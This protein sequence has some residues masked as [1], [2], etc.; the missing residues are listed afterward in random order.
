MAWAAL[1]KRIAATQRRVVRRLGRSIGIPGSTPALPAVA[2]A[3]HNDKTT[4]TK[5]R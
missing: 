4:K 5:A 3:G 2:P 1:L